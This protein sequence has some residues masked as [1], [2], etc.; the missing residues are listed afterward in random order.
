[1]KPCLDVSTKRWLQCVRSQHVE[2]YAFAFDLC[3]ARQLHHLLVK[4][5]EII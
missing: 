2:T 3:I 4:N 1:M 5:V